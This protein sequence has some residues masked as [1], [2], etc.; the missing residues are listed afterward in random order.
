M[1]ESKRARGGQQPPPHSGRP[2]LSHAPVL[3]QV[4]PKE[5][6]P[7]AQRAKKRAGGVQERLTAVRAALAALAA[8]AGGKAPPKLCKALDALGRA[9]V[10]AADAL[11]VQRG[12]SA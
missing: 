4:L 1:C 8:H 7:A 3:S 12:S 10:R 2:L 9:K 5:L 11:G 6:R